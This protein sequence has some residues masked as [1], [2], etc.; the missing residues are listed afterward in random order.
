MMNIN[1]NKK[2]EGYKTDVRLLTV[3]GFIQRKH[4][5]NSILQLLTY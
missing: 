1:A 2:E 3:L 4:L 5:Y